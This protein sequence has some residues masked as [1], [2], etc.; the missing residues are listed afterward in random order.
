MKTLEEVK[1]LYNNIIDRIIYFVA[2]PVPPIPVNDIVFHTNSYDSKTYDLT[3]ISVNKE[4][5]II[6]RRFS[7]SLGPIFLCSIKANRLINIDGTQGFIIPRVST[8]CANI[9]YYQKTINNITHARDATI[10]GLSIISA[11]C[12]PGS[13]YIIPR[14]PYLTALLQY[15]QIQRHYDYEE[16]RFT[17]LK[18]E[19]GE[20][21]FPKFNFEHNH[22][23]DSEISKMTIDPEKNVYNT[24]LN[25][26]LGNWAFSYLKK[27]VLNN[28]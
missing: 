27:L 13:H 26:G 7:L 1:K 8:F 6:L 3:N 10:N 15:N 12:H 19:E 5:N 20:I 9:S 17:Y 23:V 2:I 14:A 18:P 4:I 24:N 16:S 25:M 11:S 22:I 28:Y 21:L